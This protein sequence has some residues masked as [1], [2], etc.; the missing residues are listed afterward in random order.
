MSDLLIM[1]AANL[2]IGT[3][4][5]EKSKHLQVVNLTLPTL[6][7]VTAE[8]TPG[9]GS[10][11][12][13]INMNVLKPL[14]PAFKLVGFDEEAYAA[15]GIGS[16]IPQIF[17]ARGVIQRLSDGKNFQSIATIKGVIGKITPEQFE[18]S[19]GMDHD[20]SIVEVTRY[21][22]QIGEKVYFDVDFFAMKR[23]RFGID[24]LAEYRAFLGL[25]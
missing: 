11:G 7:Y 25:V 24:E 3:A 1:K 20:H 2:F 15:A 10:M 9:G 23:I 17:T 4:D 19:K 14:Q 21:K 12:I 5:P 22:L 16:N 18:R 8:H 13:E 6:E